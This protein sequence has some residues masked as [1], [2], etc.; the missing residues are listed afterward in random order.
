MN[1]K[2]I[3]CI[4][5]DL[6]VYFKH[7]LREPDI[8]NNQ[9]F[10]DLFLDLIGFDPNNESN[11]HSWH[12]TINNIIFVID[13]LNSNGHDNKNMQTLFKLINIKHSLSSDESSSLLKVIE[14]L[15]KNTVLFC[16]INP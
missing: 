6:V 13:T 4:A 15:I 1:Q 7:M 5:S 8:I 16:V 10:L 2:K 14:L 9:L 11:W 12:L 3:D